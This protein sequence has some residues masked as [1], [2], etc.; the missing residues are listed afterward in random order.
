MIEI[1]AGSDA[2]VELWRMLHELCISTIQIEERR[3][4][5]ALKLD[6]GV[7]TPTLATVPNPARPP[8][9]PRSTIEQ[10]GQPRP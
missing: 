9:Q 2:Y 1:Q 3:D 10:T 4:G 7:W 5:V 6:G 8:Q